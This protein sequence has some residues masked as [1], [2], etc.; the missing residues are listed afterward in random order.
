MNRNTEMG[1]VINSVIA[2]R[3]GMIEEWLQQ[4]PDY[5]DF[6]TALG[7]VE[8]ILIES[9]H[10]A[11]AKKLWLAIIKWDAAFGREVYIQG[12]RDHEKIV[13]TQPFDTSK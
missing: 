8:K 12:F 6:Q 9:G 1:E 4:K 3:T 7:D 11:V 2:E 5:R 13:N 10:E